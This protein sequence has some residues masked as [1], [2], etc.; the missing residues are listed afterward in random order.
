MLGIGDIEKPDQSHSTTV[1]RSGKTTK[2]FTLSIDRF[3]IFH[4]FIKLDVP[5]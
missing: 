4:D 1:L 5:N 2:V 3:H